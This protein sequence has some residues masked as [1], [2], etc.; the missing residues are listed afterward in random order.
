MADVRWYLN[1]LRA[2]S[3]K[4]IFWRIGQKRLERAEKKTFG[5]QHIP[6]TQSLFYR[7]AEALTFHRDKL[8]MAWGPGGEDSHNDDQH[9]QADLSKRSEPQPGAIPLLGGYD[10]C[11]HKKDWHSG[12]QTENRW[13]LTFSYDLQ[14]KQRDDI[15][16]AR[17]NW[18]LNRHFQF[19]L[20]AGHYFWTGNDKFLTE[21]SDL[22]RDW[23]RE[24]PFLHGI[25]W[26]SVMETAIRDINWIYTLGFLEQACF[27]EQA[28][29]ESARTG[30]VEKT[31][32]L[33]EEL[34]NGIIN[35]TMYLC[36]HYSRY[37][38]ANNHVIVEAAAI[39]IAGL[40]MGEEAWYELSVA[41]LQC[42]IDRQNYRDGV[43]KEVSLHY[44]S[45]FMEAVGL[46]LLTMKV[47]NRS[48]PQSW[49][50][51]LGRMSRYLSDCQGRHGETVVFGDDDEGKILDLQGIQDREEAGRGGG[52]GRSHYQYVL[53]L[54][55]IVLPQRYVPEITDT[56]LLRI[57]PE[58]L[59][60]K[61]AGKPYYGN[62]KSVCYA[63]GGVS[64]LKSGDGR[65]LIGIDHGAL[66]FGSIAAH[67]HAD[68]LSF[69]MYLDGKPVFADAGTCLYHTDLESRNLFR[70]T[71]MH[72]TVTVD[73]KDQS[74]M[75]GAFLWGKRAQT[76]LLSHNLPVGNCWE[77][78]SGGSKE[79]DDGAEE[80]ARTACA[81]GSENARKSTDAQYVEA[82]HD[83]YRPVIHRR[84]VIFDGQG[85]LTICDRLLHVE[86]ETAYTVNYLLSDCYRPVEESGSCVVL[87]P[88][89]EVQCAKPPQ[90]IRMTFQ[91]GRQGD[92]LTPAAFRWSDGWVSARYGCRERTRRIQISG[93]TAHELTIVTTIQWEG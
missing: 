2:M 14:Y 35:M 60:G 4:E 82:E 85:S 11:T 22:F 10:Y 28:E 62:E 38:S 69:Q 30:A 55:S 33:R 74:E 64:L 45:F 5:K 90:R 29:S 44:Q 80:D 58:S 37:S 47:N 67:G 26:T 24:N 8:P 71:Q 6:V 40:V 88:C 93:K 7:G 19:A 89:G 73:D 75:R 20:L 41:I 66:G 34:C 32:A 50:N 59:I 15:G 76:T 25:S 23:N 9:R 79:R 63:E 39:G 86:R 68:A 17:T 42:E 52:S 83:G 48:I 31:R 27:R 21:L 57:V 72:N 54:M 16:D 77:Q 81:M 61:V 43:N 78:G 56:T 65:A 92:D 70:S 53:Q 46:L 91:A 84:K 12:F 13:P 3:G 49:R 51:T 36:S 18:E 1:R 87:A